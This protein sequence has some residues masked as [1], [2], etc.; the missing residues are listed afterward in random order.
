L[1][2][3]GNFA[4]TKVLMEKMTASWCGW[5]PENDLEL[6]AILE[7][8]GEENFIVVHHHIMDAMSIEFGEQIA[9]EFVNGT[10]SLLL[11][12]FKFEDQWNVGVTRTE[13]TA[14]APQALA[15]LQNRVDIASNHTY[16]AQ[17]RSLSINIDLSFLTNLNGDYRVNCYIVEDKVSS[18]EIDFA[19]SNYWSGEDHELGNQ[20]NPIVGFEHLKVVREILGG[21]WGLPGVLNANISAGEEVNTIFFYNVPEYIDHEKLSY[22]VLV[23]EYNDDKF[24]REIVNALQLQ[25]S[26]G[27]IHH[28]FIKE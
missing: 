5:C 12:R 19:Q 3:Q 24:Q 22:V 20:P 1:N 7:Q 13:W 16:N 27:T 6:D 8:Y 9:Q 4:Q 15:M 18:P 23:Q 10:P 17:E 14:H 2:T 28:K 26:E 21:P 11:N 25:T